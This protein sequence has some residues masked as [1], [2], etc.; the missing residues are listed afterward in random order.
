VPISILGALEKDCPLPLRRIASRQSLADV[1]WSNIQVHAFP[2]V[3]WS[4]SP[5]EAMRFMFRRLWPNG[6]TRAELRHFAEHEQG[7]STISWYG[8]SQRRRILRWVFSR[9]PRVQTL[10]VVQAALEQTA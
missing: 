2:G 6:E 3:E 9:P 10:R 5:V 7:K 1:S 8:V 4:R